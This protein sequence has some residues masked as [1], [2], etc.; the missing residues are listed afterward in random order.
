MKIS[1]TD[2]PIALKAERL[3][4][5]HHE[6]VKRKYTGEPYIEHPI[7]VAEKLLSFG[8]VTERF[9]AGA[10]LHDCLE[11]E[12]LFGTMLH[13]SE[14]EKIS[15]T[16]LTDVKFLTS[17]GGK[18]RAERKARYRDQMA[19]AHLGVKAIKCADIID[20]VTGI[21]ALDPQFASLYIE[22][23]RLMLNALKPTGQTV[24]NYVRIWS[25]ASEA[26]LQETIELAHLDREDRQQRDVKAERAF[27]AAVAEIE[28]RHA[29]DMRAFG[30]F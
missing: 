7:R 28:R 30:L 1:L 19:Q 2:K 20:N 18:N 6:G 10:L 22:E 26:C 16:V 4:R 21:V 24:T 27:L 9:L 17:P 14:I 15:R 29:D 5:A 11:D 23:Q 8:I 13:P 3:A 25:A 12:N